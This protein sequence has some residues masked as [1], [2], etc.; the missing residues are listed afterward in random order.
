LSNVTLIPS[1]KKCINISY[2]LLSWYP[3]ALFIYHEAKNGFSGIYSE[4][5]PPC[6]T[7]LSLSAKI[8]FHWPMKILQNTRQLRTLPELMS[9]FPYYAMCIPC[10]LETIQGNYMSKAP[11]KWQ[12]SIICIYSLW[13]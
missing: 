6:F 11:K 1:G 9:S 7:V 12:A 5:Y 3:I 13:L 4:T 2:S 10:S 8:D